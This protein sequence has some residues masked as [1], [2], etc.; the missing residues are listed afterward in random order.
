MI[1]P[2]LVGTPRENL[3]ATG[4]DANDLS[5]GTLASE[6]TLS[7]QLHSTGQCLL[8][9]STSLR[10]F[11]SKNVQGTFL[12]E[13]DMVTGT[14][15]VYKKS[16]SDENLPFTGARDLQSSAKQS[17]KPQLPGATE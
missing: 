17:G 1:S 16:D 7:G 9:I 2:Q 6:K 14:V 10:P 12:K 13:E 3:S 11:A 5:S 4:S 8:D 15:E